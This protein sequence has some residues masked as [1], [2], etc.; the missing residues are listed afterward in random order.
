MTVFEDTS[1]GIHAALVFDYQ[2]TDAGA[3]AA[4]SVFVWSATESNIAAYRSSNSNITLSKY[5]PWSR[6]PDAGG[7]DAGATLAFWQSAHPS[8]VTYKCPPDGGTPTSPDQ[9]TPAYEFTD[10]NVPLDIS[11]P[12]VL[13]WQV[14]NYAVPASNAGYDVIAAD[15]YNPANDY[16][17][18]GIFENGVWKQLYTGL[19]DPKYAS[20]AVAWAHA[21]RAALKALPRPLGLVPNFSLHSFAYD[22]PTIVDLVAN[23]D[24]ILDE[25]GY[26]DYGSTYQVGSAW[27][28]I[29]SFVEYVQSQGRAYFTVAETTTTQATQ[30]D[31]DWTL[32]SYL[33]G[34]GN[35]AALHVTGTADHG[36]DN[37][38]PEYA[39][40]IGTAC[41]PKQASGS[42]YVREFQT[43][44]AV[45]NPSSTAASYTI[46]AGSFVDESG[47]P[48]S[49]TLQLGPHTGALL[50][51]TSG[52]RC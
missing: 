37:W 39:S 34:K 22:D 29:E 8:W 47:N 44:I 35:A 25:A 9:V 32:A 48:A 5:I 40:P 2:V 51:Q 21:M 28:N 27:L 45:V 38:R 1:D 43:G 41:G 17:V 4:H 31:A 42:L 6:D 15:N 23:V 36:A 52:T 26:N 33:M 46:P 7:P 20:D 19:G 18:C 49:G 50:V 11:N 14:Q 16:G 10:P 30:A 24:G 13:A 12:D 3:A